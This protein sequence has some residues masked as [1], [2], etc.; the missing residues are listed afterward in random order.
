MASALS[1]GGSQG[2]ILARASRDAFAKLDPRKLTG[3]PV[4]LATE[5]VAV[6]ATMAPAMAMTGTR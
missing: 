2:A 5:V 4:I 6:L 3:N 1:A